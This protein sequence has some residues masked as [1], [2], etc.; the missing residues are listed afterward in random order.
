MSRKD[1][2]L[3]FYVSAPGHRSS[4]DWMATVSES[5]ISGK[6]VMR[7][8]LPVFCFL[9]RDKFRVMNHRNTHRS[10]VMMTLLL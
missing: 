3:T 6:M 10:K 2:K 7:N 9:G 5:A 1:A 4:T 8:R